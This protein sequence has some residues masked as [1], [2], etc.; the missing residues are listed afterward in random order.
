[1]GPVAWVFSYVWLAYFALVSLVLLAVYLSV[2]G[3]V[4]IVI[5]DSP[6][7]DDTYLE[8]TYLEFL[9]VMVIVFW[10]KLMAL[11][12]FIFLTLYVT[13]ITLILRHEPGANPDPHCSFFTFTNVIWDYM[14][15][16]V[17][18]RYRK[19]SDL[20][21]LSTAEAKQPNYVVPDLA[22]GF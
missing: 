12:A 6:D 13:V 8:L 2:N 16:I 4:D 22:S 15:S 20:D 11:D 21:D 5:N 9:C 18:R 14:L 1:M 19:E 7:S 3:A 10:H 17:T